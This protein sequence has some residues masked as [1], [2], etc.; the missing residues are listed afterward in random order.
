MI[1][2][3]I[4]F[5]DSHLVILRGKITFIEL[6]STIAPTRLNLRLKISEFVK[7]TDAKKN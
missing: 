3:N 4:T 6:I 2:F 7:E 5:T 1:F